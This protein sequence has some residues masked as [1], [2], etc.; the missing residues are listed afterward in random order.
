M[1]PVATIHKWKDAL[2]AY[3][4]TDGASNAP[5]RS[6][7]QTSSNWEDE[8]PE[9]TATPPTTSYASPHHRRPKRLH[10]PNYE[11]SD[12]APLK[13]AFISISFQPPCNARANAEA[14]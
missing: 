2:D 6:H 1:R 3:F 12:Y 7:Q 13:L 10:H 5:H 8:S 11:K 9:A 4:D 14:L